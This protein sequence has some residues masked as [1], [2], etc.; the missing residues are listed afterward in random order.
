MKISLPDAQG[1][2]SDYRL[3]GVPLP[4][5]RLGPNAARVVYSAAHVVA[6]P[7]TAN[8]PSGRA[9]V[10]WRTTMEFSC[11]LA[12]GLSRLQRESRWIR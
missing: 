8:D 7:F 3:T 2:M 11:R 10:D 5:G 4:Q 12:Q 1:R 9:T 6:D